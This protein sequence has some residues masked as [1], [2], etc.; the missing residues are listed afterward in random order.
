[1]RRAI[2]LL[3]C[4]CASAPTSSERPAASQPPH[5]LDPLTAEEITAAV[6]VL[7]AE[8]KA[9]AGARFPEVALREPQKGQAPG[10]REAWLVVL[11]RAA[12]RSHEAVVDVTN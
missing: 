11:D 7:R 12:N 2:L 4:S 10:A 1:M 8:G 9:D 6:A 3:L 5:P